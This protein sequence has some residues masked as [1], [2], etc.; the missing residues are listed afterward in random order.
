MHIDDLIHKLKNSLTAGV[1]AY[2]LSVLN[3]F[4]VA[5]DVGYLAGT[6]K[7]LSVSGW[8]GLA[9]A[10]IWFCMPNSGK[11][12]R[13]RTKNETK[14][15]LKEPLN[16][17]INRTLQ[18]QKAAYDDLK[19]KFKGEAQSGTQYKREWVRKYE[20]T[21]TSYHNES[22]YEHPVDVSTE[23]EEDYDSEDMILDCMSEEELD[24]YFQELEELE[25]LSAEDEDEDYI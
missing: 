10:S 2:G 7:I 4:R 18:E 25:E 22:K 16:V 23:D 5:Q 1:G 6:F 9:A 8:F 11:D 13:E 19:K 15:A 17:L 20:P 12:S 21:T 3:C 14:E 24:E